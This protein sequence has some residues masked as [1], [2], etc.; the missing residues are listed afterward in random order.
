V[1]LANRGFGLSKNDFLDVLKRFLDKDG[2]STP[3]KSNMPGKNIL[4]LYEAKS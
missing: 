1:E 4:E 3:F 2:R